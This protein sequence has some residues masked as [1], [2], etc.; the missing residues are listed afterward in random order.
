MILQKQSLRELLSQ[1]KQV[2][3]PCVWDCFSA[4]AVNVAGF[5]AALV[6]SAAVSYSITGLPDTGLLTADEMVGIVTRIAAASPLALIVDCEG[7]YGDTPL[8]AYRTVRRLAL[9]GASAVTLSDQCGLSGVERIVYNGSWDPECC[10]QLQTLPRKEWLAKVEAGVRAVKDT[11]CMVI[12]RTESFYGQGL[13]EAIVRCRMALEAGAD[14]ILIC[15]ITSPQEC[16][17][18][19][20]CLPGWKMYPDI[21][22]HDGKPDVEFDV[23]MENGFNLVTLHCLEKGAMWG[24][25]DYGDH[26]FADRN[27][28][29]IDGKD[30]ADKG[31]FHWFEQVPYYVDFMRW[32]DFEK[33]CFEKGKKVNESTT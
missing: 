9:A 7:G 10:A 27:T 25:L 13:E 4:R 19:H 33:E 12:A 22:S 26:T 23:M 14:M 15:G 11:D 1:G 2:I 16:E 24:M 30:M 29:Y 8:H 5:E 21:V 6:S 17:Q 28:L 18:V 32:M 20:R 31:V 3:A